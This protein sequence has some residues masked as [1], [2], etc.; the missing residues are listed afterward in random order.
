MTGNLPNP[1]SRYSV[2]A[3]LRDASVSKTWMESRIPRLNT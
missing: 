3:V 2:A 1:S